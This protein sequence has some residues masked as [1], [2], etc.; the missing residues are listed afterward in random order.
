M[1]FRRLRN[2]ADLELYRQRAHAQI[3]VLFPLEYLQRSTVMGCFDRSGDLVGGYMLVRSGPFRVL[4]SVP[5]SGRTKL[6]DTLRG[7]DRRV[8]EIT[9]LWIAHRYRGGKLS[10]HLWLR[11]YRDMIL[12]GKTRF[13]YAYTL[14][15]P[16]LGAQY[17]V[18]RPI[19]IFRGETDVLPG[20]SSADEESVEVFDLLN[21]ILAPFRNP[22]YLGDR[23]RFR[24]GGRSSRAIRARRVRDGGPLP[25][26]SPTAAADQPLL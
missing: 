23:F 4:E 26:L 13:V 24:L 18:A 2:D 9:G 14:K 7:S 22:G 12:S 6:L 15:K 8:S 1:K 25:G 3:D 20:M 10:G 16:N 19:V 21:L 5:H 17:A 11:L